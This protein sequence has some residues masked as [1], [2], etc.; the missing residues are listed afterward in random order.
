MPTEYSTTL[1]FHQTVFGEKFGQIL[2]AELI[3]CLCGTLTDESSEQSS[4]QMSV[5]V[6]HGCFLQAERSS[7]LSMGRV[8]QLGWLRVES[9]TTT[10]EGAVP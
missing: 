8:R 5:G 2:R 9:D 3:K 1:W 4:H 10:A 7:N 6:L